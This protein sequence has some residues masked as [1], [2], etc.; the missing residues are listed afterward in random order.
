[1]SD[2]S[3]A[4]PGRLPPPALLLPD[5]GTGPERYDCATPAAKF[6]EGSYLIRIEVYR[7]SESLHYA[8]HTEKIYSDRG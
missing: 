8:H 3:A 4:T 7:N 1:M 2:D 5:R 6:P